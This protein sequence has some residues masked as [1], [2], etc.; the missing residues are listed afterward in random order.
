MMMRRDSS[1]FR[2]WPAFSALA[3]LALI[4]AS[5]A[6]GF[7]QASS[8][9]GTVIRDEPTAV[10]PA[11]ERPKPAKHGAFYSF[12]EAVCWYIPNRI[13]DLTDIP[14]LYITAGDG[15]GASVR[16]TSLFEATWFQ[17]DA[18]CLGWQPRTL[19]FFTE[20]INERYFG[21]LAAQQGRKERDKTE[22]GFSFH[23]I[24]LGLNAA[25]S[26]S[27]A[28]DFVLGFVGIDLRA[29]DHGPVLGI[30]LTKNEEEG[31]T[32]QE[33]APASNPSAPEAAPARPA[34]SS[35]ASTTA[36]VAAP[37]GTPDQKPV[38]IPPSSTPQ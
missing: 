36:S 27:E 7:A 29:D 21:L 18:H 22:L 9:A 19:P 26:V 12:L 1:V 25:V 14:R 8:G 24:T 34:L 15:M 2:S 23:F 37:V 6:A 11:T 5:P 35:T 38:N 3:A 4:L 13:A 16:A 31:M 30:D 32:S 28:A 17:D 10:Q 20:N 33:K